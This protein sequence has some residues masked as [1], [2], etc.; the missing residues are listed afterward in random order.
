MGREARGHDEAIRATMS[1]G[2]GLR[3]LASAT[4][5]ASGEGWA[6]AGAGRA[7]AADL[8]PPGWCLLPPFDNVVEVSRYGA[9]LDSSHSTSA[10]GTTRVCSLAIR[11]TNCSTCV[12]WVK[13]SIH[14]AI[15][16]EESTTTRLI[17]TD[18]LHCVE[19]Y[20][21]PAKNRAELQ[22]TGWAPTQYAPARRSPEGSGQG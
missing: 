21:F 22:A 7:G 6:P 4:W 2:A 15:H 8:R 11:A 19:R 9:G 18:D 16:L 14:P 5:A 1:T 3:A 20:F 17:V 10:M 13:T 12:P